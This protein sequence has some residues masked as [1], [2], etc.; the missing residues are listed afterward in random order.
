MRA[1]GMVVFLAAGLLTHPCLAAERADAYPTVSPAWTLNLEQPVRWQRVHPMGGLVVATDL[2]L[3][4]VDTAKGSLA[5]SRCGLDGPLEASYDVLHGT[6]LF[7]VSTGRLRDRTLAVDALD[8]HVVF[9]SRAAGI[10]NILHRTV[11]FQTGGLLVLGQEKGDPTLKLFLADLVT[12]KVR[13][14]NDEVVAG[15]SPG[16]KKLAGVL[17]NLAQA[18]GKMPDP[19]SIPAPLEV[20]ADAVVL[21]SGSEIL[22][23][24]A[25]TGKILWRVPNSAGSGT[26]GLFLPDARPDVLLVG[27]EVTGTG[28]STNGA[29]PVQTCFSAHRLTDGTPLWPKPIKMKGPLNP[30][31]LLAHGALLSSGG[32]ADGGIKLVEYGTGRSLWG[33]NGKGIDSDGGIVDYARTDEGLVVTTGKDSVWTSK[34]LVYSM[35]L[36]DVGAGAVRFDKSLR[37]KGRLLWTEAV[38]KGV[39]YVTTHEVNVFDPRTGSSAMGKALASE[40]LVT[41]DAGTVLYAFT[42]ADGGLWRVDKQ[43]AKAVRLNTAAV[44][45][46]G[47]DLPRALE[48]TDD[49]VTLL[50]MQSVVGF[51]LKGAILFQAYLP[52]PRNPGWVRALAVAQSIRMGMAA[53]QAGMASAAFA[54]YASAQQ[55]GTL[56]RAVGDELARGYGQVSQAAAGAS[57]SYAAVARQRFQASADG[58]DFQFMMVQA[59]RGFGIA[60]VDK[61]TGQVRGLIPIGRDK[62]PAYSVDDVARRVYYQPDD[63]RILGYAF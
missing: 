1:A 57:A 53:A 32:G 13:W 35:N 48:V 27:T 45:L 30:P 52:A 38:P 9:D 42:P 22:K 23:I 50:G 36:V 43:E 31:V 51:D 34:G 18:S 28:M 10:A 40:S 3:Y 39:L 14:T 6:T 24:S 7:L 15:A 2:C 19:A 49:H 37:A 62:D 60:Q 20:G 46:Q 8:G 55:D 41:A 11:L 26:T 5:W 56:G 33:K 29:T 21:A 4:G 16:L 63:R 47:N 25:E 12:G 61:G 59:E 17:A 54:Q 44:H 58:R